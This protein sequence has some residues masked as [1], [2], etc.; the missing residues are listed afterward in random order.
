MPTSPTAAAGYSIPGAERRAGHESKLPQLRRDTH[1]APA[2]APSA[3][4][5]VAR[6]H[7]SMQMSGARGR[8]PGAPPPWAV[9]THTQREE[10]LSPR[11]PALA[12]DVK[13][14]LSRCREMKTSHFMSGIFHHRSPVSAFLAQRASKYFGRCLKAVACTPPLLHKW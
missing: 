8:G 1:S 14:S 5:P 11:P 10:P 13:S 3:R 4:P 12:G 7:A 2:P 6:G 9:H